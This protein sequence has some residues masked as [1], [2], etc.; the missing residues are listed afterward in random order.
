MVFENEIHESEL[1]KTVCIFSEFIEQQKKI[2]NEI[3]RNYNKKNTSENV[4]YKDITCS[5]TK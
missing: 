4:K 5:M 2:K 1:Q 3:E